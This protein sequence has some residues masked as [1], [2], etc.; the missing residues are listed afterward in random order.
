MKITVIAVGKIKEKY[1]KDALAEY[2]KRL[3]RY[4][5]LEIIEVA[6]EKTPDQASEAA[7][8]LIRAKEGERILKHIR[9]DMF[10]IT[11]E[12]GG[13]M[14]TSEEFADKIETLGVQGKSSIAFVIGGSIGLGKEVLKR[15]VGSLIS[16]ALT[17]SHQLRPV[18]LLEQVYR[19]YRIMNGE[20]Y[21]K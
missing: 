4:C 9:D 7:E 1:L 19:A 2:S 8:D 20:P 14:L 11:L 21:H 5:K 10:V 15:S 13:K 6:D 3:S 18:V 17:C 16:S 12:I